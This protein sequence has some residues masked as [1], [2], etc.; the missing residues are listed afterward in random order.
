MSN[1]VKKAVININKHVGRNRRQVFW[2]F[3]VIMIPMK[4]GNWPSVSD[5]TAAHPKRLDF[6]KTS[7]LSYWTRKG[8][9]RI[10]S[11]CF[12][13]DQQTH[14]FLRVAKRTKAVHNSY[15]C[16][17]DDATRKW[18]GAE[19]LI[20]I[21]APSLIV[22]FSIFSAFFTSCLMLFEMTFPSG[23]LFVRHHEN[24]SNS[25][26][27]MNEKCMIRY[28]D[29]NASFNKRNYTRMFSRTWFWFIAKTPT[30]GRPRSNRGSRQRELGD[31]KRAITFRD[32]WGSSELDDESSLM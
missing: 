23:R 6:A 32:D 26:P 1:Q 21:R 19:K 29:R 25:N 28:A 16:S 22:R 7:F 17:R 13:I 9:T 14:R 2:K 30:L 18:H 3:R 24:T 20:Q 15:C 12:F 31:W 4:F 11:C 27:C 5:C 8:E 10:D